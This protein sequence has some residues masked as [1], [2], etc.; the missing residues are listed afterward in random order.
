MT[1][2]LSISR[3]CTHIHLKS[4]FLQGIR[5]TRPSLTGHPVELLRSLIAKSLRAEAAT[6]EP[7]LIS[8][9]KNT[10]RIVS[11]KTDLNFKFTKLFKFKI[12]FQYLKNSMFPMCLASLHPFVRKD[13]G[14]SLAIIRFTGAIV[15]TIIVMQ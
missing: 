14:G 11:V 7:K 2:P 15:R 1:C 6:Y 13:Y 3:Y 12:K 4:H 9:F 8:K 5:N 10:Y